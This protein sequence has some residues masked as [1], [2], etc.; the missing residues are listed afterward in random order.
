MKN[1]AIATIAAAAFA[2]AAVIALLV[3]RAG[4]SSSGETPE[5]AATAETRKAAADGGGQIPEATP[6]EAAETVQDEEE[7]EEPQTEE[8][9]AE[10]AA[11][12]KA[13][14]FDSLVDKWSEPSDSGV[15]MDDIAAFAAALREVPEAMREDCLRRALNLVPD[16]NALLLAG[17]LM[18]KSQPKDFVELVYNDVL[19]R[20]EE[21]KLPILKEIYKDKNHPCWAD[22][23]W[24]FD[25]TGE[26][27]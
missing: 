17:V 7:A 26:T 12:A 27:P 10:A 6:A 18:D 16:D 20:A 9:K 19:N 15:T 13:E 5:T 23:A 21:V 11:Q 24:I 1:R 8:E 2:A 4:D 3:F 14:E 22:T 25:A